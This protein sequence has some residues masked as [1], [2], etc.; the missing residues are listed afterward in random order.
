MSQSAALLR[1]G[2]PSNDCHGLDKRV[3]V[4]LCGVMSRRHAH[5]PADGER[6]QRVMRHG[7]AVVASTHDDSALCKQRR[8]RGGGDALNVEQDYGQAAMASADG[9]HGVVISP[10][11][12]RPTLAEQHD[13]RDA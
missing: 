2:L 9:L 8:H 10:C 5:S 6:A 4:G 1:T 13:T 12:A 3:H 11:S 7:G